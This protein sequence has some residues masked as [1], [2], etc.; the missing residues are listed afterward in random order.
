MHTILLRNF[1]E[2][3]LL[4][5][6]VRCLRVI[7]CF[8]KAKSWTWVSAAASAS[9]SDS[10]LSLRRLSGSCG[11]TGTLEGDLGK[12]EILNPEFIYY[13]IP[14][15]RIKKN[16][17]TNIFSDKSYTVKISCEEVSILSWVIEILCF[18]KL[19]HNSLKRQQNYP[20]LR[21]A[22]RFRK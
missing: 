9:P 20:I 18:L 17:P 2:T 3:G 5:F 12:P 14:A 10:E 11:S 8:S 7:F 15:I 16:F 4:A 21:M 1:F 13:G 6:F 19:H 22:K